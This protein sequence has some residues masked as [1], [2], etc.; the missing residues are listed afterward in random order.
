MNSFVPLLLLSIVSLSFGQLIVGP[1]I[2][3]PTTLTGINHGP[4]NGGDPFP[5][6]LAVSLQGTGSVNCTAT[7]SHPTRILASNKTV[8]SS[9]IDPG[10]TPFTQLFCSSLEPSANSSA[11]LVIQLFK[12][13]A[14][15]IEVCPGSTYSVAMQC[16]TDTAPNPPTFN[17]TL[18][19]SEITVS[20]SDDAVLG[21]TGNLTNVPVVDFVTNPLYHLTAKITND[22]CGPATG[23]VCTIDIPSP[24]TTPVSHGVVQF[25]PGQSTGTSGCISLVNE[26][27]CPNPDSD[28]NG[29]TLAVN[30]TLTFIWAMTLT[31][32]GTLHS[33]ISCTASRIG[34]LANLA[35]STTAYGIGFFVNGTSSQS[36]HR[37]SSSSSD[38]VLNTIIPLSVFGGIM[39]FL[40]VVA[41]IT[42]VVYIVVKKVIL[43][44]ENVGF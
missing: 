35:G 4:S 9:C 39:I 15:I 17:L 31:D 21:N 2:N 19:S 44:E 34:S 27:T 28:P 29:L 12:G 25:L 24:L 14:V 18:G 30:A 16:G 13:S 3:A 11:T 32:N 23:I 40:I 36:I 22:G 20:L 38:L 33:T 1:Q 37:A 41:A 43:S 10:V 6:N 5:L 8:D 26:F 42:I 7:F